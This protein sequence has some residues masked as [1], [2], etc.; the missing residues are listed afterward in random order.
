M[1]H[2]HTR[3][4][5]P[6]LS[7]AAADASRSHAAPSTACTHARTLRSTSGLYAKSR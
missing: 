7:H 5:L 1:P 6:A 2:I 4:H 3:A